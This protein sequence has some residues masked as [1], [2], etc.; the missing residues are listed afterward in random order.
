MSNGFKNALQSYFKN[1]NK[2]WGFCFQPSFIG[3]LMGNF[4]L[5]KLSWRKKRCVVRVYYYVCLHI[6]FKMCVFIGV[7]GSLFT[8]FKSK[9]Q[10]F[11]K[12]HCK[13]IYCLQ[14]ESTSQKCNSSK[15]I[16]TRTINISCATGWKCLGF[17]YLLQ[18][19]SWNLYSQDCRFKVTINFNEEKKDII[20]A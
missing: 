16:L 13:L 7:Y 9:K 11:T 3:S 8:R 15:I 4:N 5:N 20:E 18:K 6:R 2:I 12:Q 1:C 10:L 19:Y 14:I 17:H